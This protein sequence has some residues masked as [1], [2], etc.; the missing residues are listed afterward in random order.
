MRNNLDEP[1]H[2]SSELKKWLID[3]GRDSVKKYLEYEKN[4]SKKPIIFSGDS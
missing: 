2:Q 4:G 3:N 1:S